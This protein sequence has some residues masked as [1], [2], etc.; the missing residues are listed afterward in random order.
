MENITN[1]INGKEKSINKEIIT[2]FSDVLE[3]L[4]EEVMKTL[5]E[6]ENGNNDFD[7]KELIELKLPINTNNNNFNRIILIVIVII[8]I[9]I[10]NNN[11]NN[12]EK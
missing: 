3:N 2:D 1:K 5:I 7:F 4:K 9:I 10:N 11:N 8:I 6:V 12:I